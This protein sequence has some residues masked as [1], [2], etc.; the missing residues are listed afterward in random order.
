MTMQRRL[1][2]FVAVA[3]MRI[4][5]VHRVHHVQPVRLQAIP[6]TSRDRRRAG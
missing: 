3:R 4:L 6:D 1:D 5:A 2:A